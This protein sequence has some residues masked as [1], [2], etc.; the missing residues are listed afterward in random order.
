[1]SALT[2]INLL[3]AD[4]NLIDGI[5]MADT[6][7]SDE[8]E[9]GEEPLLDF[10]EP[11]DVDSFPPL[12]DA[13]VEATEEALIRAFNEARRMETSQPVSPEHEIQLA[14]ALI[15]VTSMAIENP[16]F[17]KNLSLARFIQMNPC[18]AVSISRT[19]EVLETLVDFAT[20]R[21]VKAAMQGNVAIPRITHSAPGSRPS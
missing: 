18:P 6:N 16:E 21:S 10:S 7:S 1:M 5:I 14:N 13:E 3:D 9:D 4:N 19:L 2:A 8:A 15:A 12:A 11:E 20:F 17:A